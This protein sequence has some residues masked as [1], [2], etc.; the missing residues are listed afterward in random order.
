MSKLVNE[1]V[2]EFKYFKLQRQNNEEIKEVKEDIEKIAKVLLKFVKSNQEQI[3]E[4]EDQEEEEEEELDP[5][6]EEEFEKEQEELNKPLNLPDEDDDSD[7][8]DADKEDKEEK[9]RILKLVPKKYHGTDKQA[10]H[11]E[12]EELLYITNYE[13][14][15]FKFPKTWKV[16]FKI[17]YVPLLNG[18]FGASYSMEYN[19]GGS[20]SGI[21]LK[22]GTYESL[23]EIKIKFITNFLKT[24]QHHYATYKGDNQTS[25]GKYASQIF[26]MFDEYTKYLIPKEEDQNQEITVNPE[27]ES[28]SNLQYD[29]NNKEKKPIKKTTKKIDKKELIKDTSK[30]ILKQYQKT[31]E[32]I[33]YQDATKFETMINLFEKFN[34]KMRSIK[35]Y[36]DRELKKPFQFNWSNSRFVFPCKNV[37]QF[38]SDFL[39]FFKKMG[40]KKA[41]LFYPHSI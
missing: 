6:L 40:K 3:P 34:N 23:E 14:I 5:E 7:P 13:E 41:S 39:E 28:K 18:K 4:E 30:G 22:Y 8:Y 16:S 38:E 19:T 26:K 1:L 10:W 20:S 33:N 2:K 15:N 25:F 12:D 36:P 21:N 32:S 17:I 31:F 35:N 37:V 11:S 24:V 29:P 27:V 9:E